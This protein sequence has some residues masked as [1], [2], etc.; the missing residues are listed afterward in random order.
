[1]ALSKQ[2]IKTIEEIVRKKIE[3]SFDMYF[4]Y[5]IGK[6]QKIDM[7]YDELER[8]LVEIQEYTREI[9]IVKVE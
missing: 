3:K 7:T 8:R 5:K 6:N 4:L 1:M 2:D 9:P